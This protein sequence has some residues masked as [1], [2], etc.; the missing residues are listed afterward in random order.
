MHRVQ[1]ANPVP[2]LV[3]LGA[4]IGVW[5]LAASPSWLSVGAGYGVRE[6]FSL[7][8]H[9]FADRSPHVHGAQWALCFRCTGILSG[10]VLG[11]A[12]GP[13]LG[14]VFARITSA[15]G[16]GHSM[17]LM[18]LP[19]AIDWLLGASGLWANTPLSRL[20]TGVLFGLGAGWLLAEALLARHASSLTTQ[21]TS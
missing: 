10:L 20:L 21:P 18:G 9:Q 11:L 12:S 8:C 4:T 5:L 13:W 14:S 19:T 2:W 15:R 6:A 16:A 17:I 7:V 3:A 1:I